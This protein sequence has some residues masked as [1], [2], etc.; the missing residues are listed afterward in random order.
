MNDQLDQ[1][2]VNLKLKKIHKIIDREL[3]HAQ[4]KDSSYSDFLI[5]LLRE[6]YLNK[7]ERSLESRIKRAKLPQRW[8]LDSFP[9]KKQP[10]ISPRKIKQLAELAFI[11]ETQNV[12]FIG[13]TGVGKTGLASGLMLKAL[14]NGYKGLFVKAQDLFD[15]MYASLADRS[16]RKLINRLMNVDV[17]LIDELGYLNLKPEQTNIFFKLMDERYGRKSTII[18]TNLEYSEW[19][20][21]LGNKTMVDALLD[22]IRHRCHTI[23]ID[24]SSLRDREVD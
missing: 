13:P 14:E 3:K 21:F 8:S 15:E 11:P 2:L 9:Y 7:Q 23:T 19:Y 17:L 1:L 10:G 18:T 24:G 22:R 20:D 4:K 5:R 12:I 6:E 16:S